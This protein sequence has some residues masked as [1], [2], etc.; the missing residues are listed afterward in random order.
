M[1]DA[2]MRQ[3]GREREGGGRRERTKRGKMERSDL[4]GTTKEIIMTNQRKL[5]NKYTQIFPCVRA[6]THN[7]ICIHTSVCVCVGGGVNAYVYMK[8]KYI[9][10]CT[11]I[12]ICIFMCMCICIYV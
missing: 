8:K 10:I 2:R 4:R 11:C 3:R 7:Y 12:C 9:C 1:R 6:Y 5:V